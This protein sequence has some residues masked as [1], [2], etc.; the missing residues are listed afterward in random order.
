[1]KKEE[2]EEYII[3]E[4]CEGESGLPSMFRC[5]NCD[6]WICE[7]CWDELDGDNTAKHCDT[8]PGLFYGF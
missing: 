6:K 7:E 3:C 4:I 1:M 2:K 5:T 8:C